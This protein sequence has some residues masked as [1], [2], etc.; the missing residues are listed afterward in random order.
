MTADPAGADDARSA[1]PRRGLVLGAGGVLG[2]AWTVGALSALEVEARFDAR[3]VDVVVGTSAGSVIAALLACGSSVDEIRRHHQG[4][5]APEDP[6]IAYQYDGASARP[7]RPGLGVGSPRLLLQSV[8]HPRNASAAVT[9]SGMLPPGRGTLQPVHAMIAALTPAESDD[10]WPRCPRPWIVATDYLT[11]RR[12]VFG[13]D[14]FEASLADAVVASCSIPAWYPPIAIDGRP[15]ID[16]GTTSNTSVDLLGHLDLDEVY[17][18]APM[19]SVVPDHPRSPVARI[20]RA[21]RRGITRGLL[22]DV[23]VLRAA[24]T[25]VIVVTPGAEDLTV[26]GANLMNPRRRTDVLTTG[27]RTSAIQLRAQLAMRHR[28]STRGR[29]AEQRDTA[30][31]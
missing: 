17:V 5:P 14:P 8:R 4:T 31:R 28:T 25:R 19:A 16:G 2:F 10:G 15:Y 9:L 18:L 26:I 12:A 6:P 1:V 27:M 13:R 20:E 29:P 7:P 24:G 11:G 22:A 3:S 21:I 23:D 30:A